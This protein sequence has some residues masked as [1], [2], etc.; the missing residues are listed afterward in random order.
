M[1]NPR[2]SLGL[3]RPARSLSVE[4]A[5]ASTSSPPKKRSRDMEDPV[6]VD[7]D[8]AYQPQKLPCPHNGVKNYSDWCTTRILKAAAD[9]R[10]LQAKIV[11]LHQQ[12]DSQDFPDWVVKKFKNLCPD[13]KTAQCAEFTRL[14]LRNA[15]KE[16]TGHSDKKRD[17]EEDF[18][19]LLQDFK[20]QR[21]STTTSL[22]LPDGIS[23]R[24]LK[25]PKRVNLRLSS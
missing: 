10:R 6:D 1:P 17:A 13:A 19:A 9:I 8:Y 22:K 16:L 21:R 2:R 18:Q 24:L 25:P 12:L 15:E 23:L 20:I 3:K 14:G 4:P 7:M 11:R 5:P